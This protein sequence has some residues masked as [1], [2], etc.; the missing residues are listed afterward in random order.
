MFESTDWIFDDSHSHSSPS[1]RYE[2]LAIVRPDFDKY[3]HP[4]TAH[5]VPQASHYQS[6]SSESDSDSDSN[7]DGKERDEENKGADEDEFSFSPRTKRKSTNSHPSDEERVVQKSVYTPP[8]DAAIWILRRFGFSAS[9]QRMSVICTLPESAPSDP[10]LLFCK[11]SPEMIATLCTPASLPPN[12]QAVLLDFVQKGYRVLGCA[13]RSLPPLSPSDMLTAARK[14]LESDLTFLG[15]LIMQ[16]RLKDD[17]AD[18]IKML[19]AAEFRTVMITGFFV[20]ISSFFLVRV[21]IP[22]LLL[23]FFRR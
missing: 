2:V 16:N 3:S 19:V 1:D 22:Y 7:D 21:Y 10:L 18:V 5:P 13:V 20:N 8:R 11:G 6:N 4:I 12:F 17:T 15:F 23:T 9:L 14:D